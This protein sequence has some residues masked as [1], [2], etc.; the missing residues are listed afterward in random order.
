MGVGESQWEVDGKKGK[1]KGECNKKNMHILKVHNETH[2]TIA[3][4]IK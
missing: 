4:M 2:L 1:G 3:I